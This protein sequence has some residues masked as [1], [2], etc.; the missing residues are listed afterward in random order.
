MGKPASRQ[1]LL[2][3]FQA[4]CQGRQADAATEACPLS[5]FQMG[6]VYYVSTV[7]GAQLKPGRPLPQ[8]GPGA[9]LTVWGLQ[10]DE[11][12]KICGVLG[13]PTP[14]TWPEGLQLAAAMG[15]TFPS[16]AP[17]PLHQL[18][19]PQFDGSRAQGLTP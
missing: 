12:Y 15:F 19:G 8:Q 17:I 11:L 14:G 6:A 16:F 2:R 3:M 1:A 7:Q 18:V 13:S 9:A 4:A 5:Y 10:V